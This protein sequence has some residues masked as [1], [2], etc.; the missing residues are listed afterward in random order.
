MKA[1]AAHAVA[2]GGPQSREWYKGF[3]FPDRFRDRLPLLWSSGD[4]FIYRV[5]ERVPGLARVVRKSDLV[6]HPPVN[7]IDVG[8]MRPFVAALDDPALPVASWQWHDTNTAAIRA[9]LTPE[10]VIAVALNYH[11]GW[12]ASVA[13]KNVPVR[14]DG[15]G[16]VVIEPGCSGPCEIEMHWSPGIEPWIVVPLALLTLAGSLAWSL[17]RR[18][19]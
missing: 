3:K 18:P 6:R 14:S 10:Q 19:I 9:T 1:Y 16:F 7:G 17:R 13:G 15:L 12:H 8:E 2:I 11:K 4:D 5:P